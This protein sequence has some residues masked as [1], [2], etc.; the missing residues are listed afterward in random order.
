MEIVS[1]KIGGKQTISI[2]H[3]DLYD[4]KSQIENGELEIEE[5]KKEKKNIQPIKIIQKPTITQKNKIKIKRPL[6]LAAVVGTFVMFF[7]S[8]F[9]E[10]ISNY[11][12]RF[13]DKLLKRYNS[14]Q[15]S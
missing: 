7:F 2:F 8:F 10:Y 11:K 1:A 4:I 5:I 12:R 9:L 14:Q 6:I 13:P 15:E 3:P